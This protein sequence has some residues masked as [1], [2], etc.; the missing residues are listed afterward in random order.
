MIKDFWIKFA[1][2]ILEIF[3][4]ILFIMLGILGLL[5]T[6][7][8]LFFIWKMNLGFYLFSSGVYYLAALHSHKLFLEEDIFLYKIGNLILSCFLLFF[9]IHQYQYIF[10]LF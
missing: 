2:A 9:S 3:M 4:L 1:F 7:P 10:Q 5:T 6:L 8:L